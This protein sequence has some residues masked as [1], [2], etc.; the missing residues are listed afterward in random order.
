[1]NTPRIDCAGQSDRGQVRDTNE[2]R[3]LTANLCKSLRIGQ[4]NLEPADREGLPNGFAG[5]LL[6]VADGMG[7]HAAG[8]LASALA[9]RSI[10]RYTVKCMRWFFRLSDDPEDDFLDE[11]REA[12][13][14]SQDEVLA[15]AES[16]PDHEGMGTT[17][18][19]AYIVWPRLYVVHAGD[20]RAY[21]LRD[22]KLHQ[23]TRDH[24]VAQKMVDE[25]AMDEE[26]AEQTRFSHMLWNFVGNTEKGAFQPELYKAKLAEGDAVLLCSDGLT[27]HVGDQE[28]A[29]RI[30]KGER[31]EDTCSQLV[32]TVNESGGKDNVTV[33]LAKFMPADSSK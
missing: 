25:G 30:R 22:T 5:T 23:I 2:D 18:T 15:D 27:K 33:V 28:I 24:T 14:Y 32:K 7:G 21:L 13:E 9:V 3:F 31:A 12:L 8:D 11:L 20:S 16:E 17:L 19:A 1:M 6:V 26:R 4:T 29:E 10:V